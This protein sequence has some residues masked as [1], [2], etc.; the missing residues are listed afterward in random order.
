[1]SPTSPV[2]LVARLARK[3]LREI[4]RDRRTIVTLVLM[5]VLL[6]PLL[7]VAFRQY[8]LT[9]VAPET[10]VGYRVAIATD[11]EEALF[12]E[13]LS[14]VIR[15]KDPGLGRVLTNDVEESVRAGDA[16]VGLVIANATAPFDPR[17]PSRAI[18]CEL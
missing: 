1:M 15:E 18:P 10:T 11:A 4:L 8:F 14:G 5:P 16:D 13:L 12:S 2:S 17:D 9:T 7:S 6:Y 3:E